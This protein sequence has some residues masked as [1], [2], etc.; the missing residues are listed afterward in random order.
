MD[1][2]TLRDTDFAALHAA[3]DAYDK[4]HGAFGQHLESWHSGVDQ[5]LAASG[6]TGPAADAA[7]PSLQLTTGELRAA[8]SEVGQIGKVLR[9]GADALVLVQSA[10]RKALEDVRTA[11]MSVNEHGAVTWGPA[12][13]ADQHDP[14][15]RKSRE[16]TATALAA[17][18][19]TALTEAGTIDQAVAARLQ[20]YTTRAHDGTGL[21]PDSAGQDQ[22]DPNLAVRTLLRVAV[23]R[24]GA[25]PTEVNAWWNGLPADEQQRLIKDHPDLVGNRDGIPALARDRANRALLAQHLATYEGHPPPLS[26]KDELRLAG[27]RKINERLEEAEGQDPPVLLLGIGAE[28]Q[29]RAILSFGNPDTAQNVTSLVGGMGTELQRIGGGDAD[30]AKAVYDSALRADPTRST[31]SIAWLGYDAPLSPQRTLD[32][33]RA[34]SGV[35]AYRT[36]LEG[37]RVTH[38]GPPAHVTAQG[39][40]FGS[41]LVGLAARKPAG[42]AAD[43][44]ILV[45]SPGTDAFHASELSVGAAHTYVGAAGWDYVSHAGWYT[46]DP[47]SADFSAQRFA[48]D[49][50][51][52]DGT[53]HSSYWDDG[54]HDDHTS[55]DNI[56]EI[57]SGH[58]DRITKAVGRRD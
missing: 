41:L 20:H 40:S 23:P 33:G 48:V 3:A 38:Q 31:A 25:P 15:Y 14:E 17:R 32:F 50:G 43:D 46:R 7:T 39:H 35:D 51:S 30:R 1:L 37:Q 13:Y 26:D 44:I 34:R 28:G 49:V 29:G 56:G 10:L 5:R 22:L 16:R 24:D 57:V 6:W 21:D 8:H 52:A 45:G 54:P 42:L 47:A 58:G 55:I 12:P 2:A 27:F 53:A 4:L 18:I 9:T 11:G 36:F 19:G